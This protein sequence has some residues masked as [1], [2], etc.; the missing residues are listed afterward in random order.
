MQETLKK[1]AA[2]RNRLR[3]ISIVYF[4]MLVL[5]V[6]MLFIGPEIAGMLLS[7]VLL[8]FY[9][10]WLRGQNHRFSD[11]A[12]KAH[13]LYGLAKPLKEPVFLGN[14]GLTIKDL[15]EMA[16]LPVRKDDR[17]LLT[18]Q[19]FEGR[20]DGGICRGW[21][22][23][24]HYQLGYGKKNYAFLIGTILT[25]TWDQTLQG[26]PDWLFVKKEM[27]DEDILHQFFIEKGYREEK[28][29]NDSLDKKFT[30]GIRGEGI[31]PED[32]LPR[33]AGLSE[34]LDRIGA[35]R[36]TERGAAVFLDHRF[37]TATLKV[38]DLPTEAQLSDNPLPERDDIWDFFRFLQRRKSDGE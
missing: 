22:V 34:R 38:R 32:I 1:L 20:K 27:V 24:F 21:E 2:T 37:Y 16:I 31:L 13:I 10:G 4:C 36:C 30:S 6:L 3:K 14:T 33:L 8:A 12:N 19:G 15:D 5:A 9:F 35:V 7:V 18:R 25:K 29:G 17:S 11:E 26:S 28:T 23:T